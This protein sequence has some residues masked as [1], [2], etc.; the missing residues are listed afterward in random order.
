MDGR[1]ARVSVAE[2]QALEPSST[3][4]PDQTVAV[5]SLRD[6]HVDKPLKP[7]QQRAAAFLAEGVDASDVARRVGV[8]GETIWRWKQ[9]ERFMGLYEAFKQ[10][11][12]RTVVDRFFA[13]TDPALGVVEES[14]REG[15]PIIAMQLLRLIAP[16]LTDIRTGPSPATLR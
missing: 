5:V 12:F 3:T 6:D 8:R 9:D 13:L 10:E 15:D 7:K 14:L 2:D 1:S 4:K 16:S 11:M